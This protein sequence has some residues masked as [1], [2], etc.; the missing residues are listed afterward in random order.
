MKFSASVVLAFAST[1]L[2][3]HRT[4]SAFAFAPSA[5][6]S[7][8]DPVGGSFASQVVYDADDN[9]ILVTGTTFGRFWQ[10]DFEGDETAGCFLATMELPNDA[11]NQTFRYYDSGKV[12]SLTAHEG[13]SQLHKNGNKV[14]LSGYA[15][16]GGVLEELLNYA[17]VVPSKQHGMIVDINY[18][19]PTDEVEIVGGRVLQD[20]AVVNPVALE[21]RPGESDVYVVSMST[22]ETGENPDY[23]SEV[24]PQQFYP[25]GNNFQMTISRLSMN[26]ALYEEETVQNSLD[27]SWTKQYSTS[28]D[29]DGVFVSGVAKLTDD[30]LIVVGSTSG[31]G[32]AFGSTIS[33]GTDT[34]GFI[35]KIHPV[36]GAIRLDPNDPRHQSSVRVESLENKEDFVTGMCYDPTETKYFYV[37]GST[38]GSLNGLVSDGNTRGFLMKVDALSLMPVWTEEIAAIPSDGVQTQVEGVSCA[39]TPDGS[40]IYVSGVVKD[41]AVLALSGTTTSFGGDDV[42]V[43]KY[44]TLDGEKLFVRQVGSVADDSLAVRGSLAT[45]TEGNAILVGNTEGSM[46]RERGSD[47]TDVAR[48]DVFAMT[49]ARSD[50]TYVFPIDHPEY[51]DLNPVPTVP[52]QPNSSPVD[53]RFPDL[54]E[55]PEFPE[56]PEPEDTPTIIVPGPGVEVESK[57]SGRG[58]VLG[59][60]TMFTLAILSTYLYIRRSQKESVTE[61][62]AV[63]HYLHGFDVEDV[64]LKHSAT[65]GWHCSYVNGLAHGVNARELDH[66]NNSDEGLMPL[67]NHDVLSSS[68]KESSILV[69]SLFVDDNDGELG[70]PDGSYY[71]DSYDGLSAAYGRRNKSTRSIV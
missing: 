7:G 16:T 63:L 64:D 3:H 66:S 29:N 47:E 44:H 6:Q 32:A 60:V 55:I 19:I 43:A 25:Y 26:G 58:L 68:M 37:V 33:K 18:E 53:E 57:G 52:S 49:F 31:Y 4:G 10:T 2:A 39:I 70:S 65:G 5:L 42:Y 23:N 30:T 34:D 15:E 56:L 59:L 41:N 17:S 22:D 8:P 54:P 61:R 35:T 28:G 67:N 51:T 14:F 36:T 40:E 45:D 9:M 38:S 1:P 24:D 62:D 11:N 48:M 69:D 27:E 21:T 20:T 13:C 50:G 12:S 71:S 46:F